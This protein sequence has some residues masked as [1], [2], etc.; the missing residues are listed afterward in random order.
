MRS[1]NRRPPRHR[2]A[3]K[4]RKPEPSGLQGPSMHEV[5]T[6]V[7]PHRAFKTAGVQSCLFGSVN[8][9]VVRGS[10]LCWR[11]ASANRSNFSALR[12]VIM[13]RGG[14]GF[15]GQEES[16]WVLR[17]SLEVRGRGI[18]RLG[19]LIRHDAI[20]LLGRRGATGHPSASTTASN[21]IVKKHVDQKLVCQDER[22]P[23]H[24]ADRPNALVA[25][26]VNRLL[27]RPP[28]RKP[29]WLS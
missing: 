14:S 4:R 19:A 10:L 24:C 17:G 5:Q 26:G 21:P 6:A 27:L 16:G 11:E 1:S 9:G 7:R 18:P 20:S 13:A 25:H 29:H 2:C 22:N 15:S 23:L 28:C 3:C 8:H 12:G